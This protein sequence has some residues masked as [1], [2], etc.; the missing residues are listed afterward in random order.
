MITRRHVLMLLG[1][2]LLSGC[3]ALRPG[4]EQPTVSLDSLRMLPG[5]GF[6]PRFA[7]GLRVV[8]PNN[9]AL[10]LRGMSYDVEVDGHRLLTGVAG[11][12]SPVPAYSE[13]RIEVES[14]VDL[15]GGMRLVS[16]LMNQTSAEGF[17]YAFRTRLDV[18][19]MMGPL[20]LTDRGRIALSHDGNETRFETFTA[21]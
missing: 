18:G 14:G 15:V 19:G 13:G 9:V 3:A 8:N 7:L 5:D 16:R 1:A 20:T 2:G 21:S 10:R 11:N 4:Y 12:L 6:A 17:D